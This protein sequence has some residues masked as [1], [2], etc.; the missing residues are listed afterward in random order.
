MPPCLGSSATAAVK[1]TAAISSEP[2]T[3]SL[4][5]RRIAHPPYSPRLPSHGSSGAL[6]PGRS[7]KI[8]DLGAPLAVRGEPGRSAAIHGAAPHGPCNKLLRKSPQWQGI[9]TR[10]VDAS[11]SGAAA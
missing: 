10:L 5:A 8:D 3:T 2:A 11:G 4:N 7:F 9:L 1:E 6:G